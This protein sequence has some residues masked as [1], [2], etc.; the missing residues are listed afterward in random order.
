MRQLHF[1]VSQPTAAAHLS[2]QEPR[3]GVPEIFTSDQGSQFTQKTRGA[4][5]DPSLLGPDVDGATVAIA[6]MYTLYIGYNAT[7]RI[8]YF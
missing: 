5:G 3:H 6:L 4:V 8:P 1:H 2:H 7:V